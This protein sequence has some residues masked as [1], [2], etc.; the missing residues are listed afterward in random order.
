[1]SIADLRK[2]YGRAVLT[3]SSVSADPFAQFA[4]WFDEALDAK[5]PEANAMGVSTVGDGGRPS[6]RIL[7]VKQ[8]DSSGFTWFTNYDSRKGRDLQKNPFAA[9]L[10]HWVELER[11]VRIEGRVERVPVEESETYFQRRPLKSRLGA[12]ASHQSEPVADRAILEARF[13]EAAQKYGDHPPR[14]ENWGGYRLVPD[15]IEFWQGRDSRLHD[16]ILYTRL[17]DGKWQIGRLQP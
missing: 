6:S 3:E 16:R 1:M 4:K 17:P 5:I 8:F 12:V 13:D 11:E 9:L 14:P 10:F 7:L 15:T 2:E